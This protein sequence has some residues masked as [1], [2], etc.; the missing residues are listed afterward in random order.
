[1]TPR[2]KNSCGFMDFLSDILIMSLS[3][4][5]LRSIPSTFWKRIESYISAHKKIGRMND[6]KERTTEKKE[7]VREEWQQHNLNKPVPEKG[8][9]LTTPIR[10]NGKNVPTE[11]GNVIMPGEALFSLFVIQQPHTTF[12]GW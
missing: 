3:T 5:K 9:V 1:M 10:K 11:S 2:F 8:A 12:S 6:G 7:R 4:E